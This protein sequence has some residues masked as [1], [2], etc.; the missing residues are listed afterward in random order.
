MVERTG[1]KP[2][3][4]IDEASVKEWVENYLNYLRD[5][6]AEGWSS[7]WDDDVIIL[8]PNM[9]PVHGLEAWRRMVEPSFGKYSNSYETIDLKVYAEH[10]MAY[11]RWIGVATNVPKSGGE[12]MRNENKSV[13]LLRRGRLGSLK[14]V[15]CIWSHNHPPKGERS[16]VYEK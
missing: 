16:F 1:V 3:E 7:L 2:N 9:P 11:V 6:D 12:P 5:G 15:E 10:T 4:E 14:A 8:P 13:W